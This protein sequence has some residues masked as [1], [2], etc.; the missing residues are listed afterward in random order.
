MSLIQRNKM[1]ATTSTTWYKR[2]NHRPVTSVA[3]SD[4]NNCKEVIM[5][6][7]SI[8]ER[9]EE[10]YIVDEETGCWLWQASKFHNG[11]G[12][13]WKDGKVC[14]AH[15]FSWEFYNGPIPKNIC[16]CHKCD[17][18]CCINP[19]CLFIGTHQDNMDDKKAKGR[20]SDQNGEKN[21]SSKLKEKEVLAIREILR[22]F[23]GNKGLSLGI[24][25]F[26]ARWFGVSDSHISNIHKGL[27]WSHI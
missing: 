6:K 23:P 18:P 10:K 21:G 14:Y 11:Y 16:V 20:Q 26:L 12:K 22:R 2:E 13:F 7:R 4:R 19:R 17:N 1:L 25:A 27:R 24:Q 3:I 9:F 15:R 5:A 8:A